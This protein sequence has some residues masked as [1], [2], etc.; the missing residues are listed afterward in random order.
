MAIAII[1]DTDT[2]LPQE[3]LDKFE[4][5]QYTFSIH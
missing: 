3:S 5:G 4:G 2:S 1:S